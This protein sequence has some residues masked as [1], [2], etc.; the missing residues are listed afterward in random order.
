MKVQERDNLNLALRLIADE[1]IGIGK[2]I[3]Y[4][5]DHFKPLSKQVLMIYLREIYD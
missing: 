1:T 3:S 2:L 5:Y 4:G